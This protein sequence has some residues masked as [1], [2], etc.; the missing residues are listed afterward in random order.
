MGVAEHH[1]IHTGKVCWDLFFVVDHIKGHATQGNC[2]IVGDSFRPL[3]VV[4]APNDV[5]GSVLPQFVYDAGFI[6]VA[7]VENGVDVFQI[8]QHLG[9]KQTMGVGEN[10]KFHGEYLLSRV[11]FANLF[12]ITAA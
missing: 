11:D 4:I 3:F 10:G 5:E 6:D 7:A 2:E 1:C 12:Q 9:P 8:F